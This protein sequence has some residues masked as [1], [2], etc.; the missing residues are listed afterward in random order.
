MLDP[1][2]KTLDPNGQYF[3]FAST[4]TWRTTP[5]TMFRYQT[6]GG[7]GWG[8]PMERDPEWVLRD[9]RDEYVSIEGARHDYGVAILGDPVHDPEGLRIDQAETKLK[10]AP[11]MS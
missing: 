7:G 1:E 5:N 4:P 10:H 9:V 8:K 6:A 3:Y 11:R 2:T